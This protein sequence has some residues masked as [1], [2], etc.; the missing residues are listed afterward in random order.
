MAKQE[1]M[2]ILLPSLATNHK[3]VQSS[4]TMAAIL[5]AILDLYS[6]IQLA[7]I[8]SKYEKTISY[9][10]KIRENDVFSIIYAIITFGSHPGCHTYLSNYF[11]HSFKV[12][13]Y[14]KDYS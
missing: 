2:H 13:K 7:L 14:K 3:T 8:T 1:I 9:R 5:D 10:I 6:S 11:R 12:K 4:L